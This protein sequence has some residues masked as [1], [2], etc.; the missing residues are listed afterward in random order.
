MKHLSW[1]RGIWYGDRAGMCL[2]VVYDVLCMTCYVCI[3]VGCYV[4][5]ATLS[6]IDITQNEDF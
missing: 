2:H 6:P 4:D 1:T 5:M 3:Y